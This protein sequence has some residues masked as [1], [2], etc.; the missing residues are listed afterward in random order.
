MNADF[1]RWENAGPAKHSGRTCA[2][3]FLFFAFYAFFAANKSFNERKLV[4]LAEFADAQ[5]KGARRFPQM[6][7]DSEDCRHLN[8]G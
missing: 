3:R 1:R 5:G 7:T 4:A 8:A 6:D 2:P